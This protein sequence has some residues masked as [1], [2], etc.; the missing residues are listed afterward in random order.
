LSFGEI[1]GLVAGALTTGSFLPQVVRVYK[2]RS[3]HEISL[4]FTVL[5]MVGDLIWMGY[6]IYLSSIPIIL[7]NVLGALMAAA[8]L[9]AKIRYGKTHVGGGSQAGR[10]A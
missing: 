7:W 1:L 8:L 5:F 4:F 3:A 6:G 9:F 10:A 2:L